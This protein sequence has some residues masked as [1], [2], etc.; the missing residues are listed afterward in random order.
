MVSVEEFEGVNYPAILII[1]VM[2]TVFVTWVL[3]G[4]VRRYAVRRVMLDVPNA[5]SSHSVPT[6]RGGGLAI[7]AVFI[8]WGLLLVFLR[9]LSANVAIGLLGGGVLI[10]L[11]GYIDDHAALPAKI[12]FL[13]HLAAAVLMIVF[14]GGVPS[15][16][17]FM[18]GMH[19]Q[20]A[21]GIVGIILLTW[22][23]NLFNFM[24]GIDGIAASEAVFVS[25]AGAVL[26]WLHNGNSGLTLLMLILAAATSGFLIWNWPPARIFMGDVGSGFL[27][28][29][30]GG[31]G[32]AASQQGAMSMEVWAILGGV[33][34]TDATLTLI[35]RVVRGDR[36]FEAHRMH[37][38]Q[39]LA[40]RW[41]SHRPVTIGVTIVNLF[42]LLPWAYMASRFPDRAV[43]CL[44]GALIPLSAA[45]LS[46]GAGKS[47]S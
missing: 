24:D 16:S 2:L 40:R 32:L 34:L 10:A 28:F 15:H 29:S 8:A 13:V 41:K 7:A 14:V 44:A 35:R 37:G 43:W 38:Y 4:A 19:G 17:L 3:T 26:Y 36:W 30:L 21:G 31:L 45:L 12:R 25:I 6:A 20:L 18:L 11:I 5:R 46:I 39:H 33:F 47:E 9:L 22:S 27:G 42:W 1:A 23:T